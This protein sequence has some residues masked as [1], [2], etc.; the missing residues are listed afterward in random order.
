[1]VDEGAGLTLLIHLPP[2][3]ALHSLPNSACTSNAEEFL[4]FAE[5]ALQSKDSL[6][7]CR[8][9]N[10]CRQVIR[11]NAH[12]LRALIVSDASFSIASRASDVNKRTLPRIGILSPLRS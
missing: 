1:M 2:I 4:P 8:S 6:I 12:S 10:L 7:L 11:D 9:R 3:Q 5:L